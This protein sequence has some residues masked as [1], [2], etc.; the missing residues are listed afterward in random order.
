MMMA[1]G[2]TDEER[3]KPIVL[4]K[5]KGVTEQRYREI[6]EDWKLW[7]IQED[8]MHL[9]HGSW[10]LIYPD[11]HDQEDEDATTLGTDDYTERP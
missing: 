10:L 11:Q 9:W 5:I 8:R 7:W 6:R 1:F 3:P 2:W 4:F